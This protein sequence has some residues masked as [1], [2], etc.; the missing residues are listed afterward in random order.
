MARKRKR[1]IINTNFNSV[2]I[3]DAKSHIKQFLKALLPQIGLQNGIDYW[4]TNNF[5]RIRHLKQLTG[6]ILITLKEVFSVFNFYWE[7]PR[8]LVWF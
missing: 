4:V 6:K 5:L 7:S 1:C 2:S 3:K 8:T